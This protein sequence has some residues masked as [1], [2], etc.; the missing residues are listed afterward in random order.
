MERKLV[1]LRWERKE[2]KQSRRSGRPTGVKKMVRVMILR[3][4]VRFFPRQSSIL[5]FTPQPNEGIRA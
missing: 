2:N 3:L 1:P 4:K 5:W